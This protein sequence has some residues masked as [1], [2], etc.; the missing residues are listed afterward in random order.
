M[1]NANVGMLP[2][3]IIAVFFLLM[4]GMR[5]R[6]GTFLGN[7]FYTILGGGIALILL[8]IGHSSISS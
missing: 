8:L 3:I 4:F 6:S 2:L 5:S 7:Y 1:A